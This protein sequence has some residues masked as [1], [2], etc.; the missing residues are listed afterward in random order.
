MANTSRSVNDTSVKIACSYLPVE[1]IISCQSS[2][3]DTLI[4]ECPVV[5]TLELVVPR[6]IEHFAIG[7]EPC[8]N[9]YLIK[10]R[11]YSYNLYPR[12]VVNANRWFSNKFGHNRSLS[13]FHTGNASRLSM[14]GLRVTDLDCYY[15]IIDVIESATHNKT[16]VLDNGLKA[17]IFGDLVANK[18]KLADV[19]V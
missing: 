3:N 1:S 6:K 10:R 14:F 8:L 13:L 2:Q 11:F 15:D 12:G 18:S 7:L 16:I 9:Y 19:V 5:S 17:N 4:V